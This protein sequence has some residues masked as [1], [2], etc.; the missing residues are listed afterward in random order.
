MIRKES[1]YRKSVSKII[2]ERADIVRGKSKGFV[3][4]KH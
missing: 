4:E 1:N 3:K 2:G